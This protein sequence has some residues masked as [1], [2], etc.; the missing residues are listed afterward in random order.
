MRIGAEGTATVWSDGRASFTSVR[1]STETSNLDVDSDPLY[2]PF[3]NRV[4]EELSQ[5]F[6]GLPGISDLE[7]TMAVIW[8]A[9]SLARKG[10]HDADTSH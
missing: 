1:G 10:S 3:V 5:G 9:Y 7:A 4:A 2:A 8:E 6:A